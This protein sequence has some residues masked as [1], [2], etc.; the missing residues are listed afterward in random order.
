MLDLSPSTAAAELLNKG[1]T[2]SS[3]LPALRKSLAGLVRPF[4]VPGSQL[5]TSVYVKSWLLKGLNA[6]DNYWLLKEQI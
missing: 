3:L 6:K 1:V 4:Y 2:S 5:N